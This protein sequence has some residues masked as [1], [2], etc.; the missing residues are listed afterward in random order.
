MSMHV[1]SKVK[2]V[3]VYSGDESVRGQVKTTWKVHHKLYGSVDVKGSMRKMLRWKEVQVA[4]IS[5]YL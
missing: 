1:T 3:T 2:T 5:D 4:K